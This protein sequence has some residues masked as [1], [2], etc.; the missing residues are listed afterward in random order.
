MEPR[1]FYTVNVTQAGWL[2]KSQYS[3]YNNASGAT[4][5][6]CSGFSGYTKYVDARNAIIMFPSSDQ[7]GGSAS[8][9]FCSYMSGIPQTTAN[10]DL[11][12]CVHLYY[13]GAYKR[14]FKFMWGS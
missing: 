7:S 9:Y 1:N 10:S 6:Q 12:L 5:S 14:I 2:T 13:S 11:V 4:N 3:Y 8:T